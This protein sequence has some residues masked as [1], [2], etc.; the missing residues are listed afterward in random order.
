MTDPGWR[1]ND[2]AVKWGLPFSVQGLKLADEDF[3]QS[4]R[5]QSHP[6]G[7]VREQPATDFT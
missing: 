7:E 3:S 4:D 5:Q 1:L 6:G 2:Q